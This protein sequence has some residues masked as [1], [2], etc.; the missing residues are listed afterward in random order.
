MKLSQ[1]EKIGLIGAFGAVILSA[2]IHVGIREYYQP[3]IRFEQGSYY[4]TNNTAITSLKLKNHGHSDAEDISI[5]SNFNSKIVD[6]SIDNKSISLITSSGGI[7]EETVN[8][9]IKRLVPDQEVFVYFA[10]ENNTSGKLSLNRNFLKEITFNGGKGKTGLPFWSWFF[11]T[12][13]VMLLYIPLMFFVEKK[14]LKRKLVAHYEKLELIVTSAYESVENNENKDGFI[15]KLDDIIGKT[16]FRKL[17]LR[18]V[19]IRAFD[20]FEQKRKKQV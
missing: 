12:V 19:G 9:T 6:I 3:D 7:G 15:Q 10:V 16:F 20:I 14:L 13:L 1:G 8:N 4:V 5:Y 18:E 11:S 17:T 2:I